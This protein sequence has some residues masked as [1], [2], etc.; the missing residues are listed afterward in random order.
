MFS[1][2][3]SDDSTRHLSHVWSVVWDGPVR[4]QPEEIAWGGW[5]T[6]DELER[7]LADPAWPF[8][9]DGRALLETYGVAALGAG[10]TPG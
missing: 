1:Q 3:Y 10:G 4:H 6:V 2:W 8:V 7:R 9:P 5:L